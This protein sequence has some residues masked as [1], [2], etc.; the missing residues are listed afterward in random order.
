MQLGGPDYAK[1]APK[2]T[3]SEGNV[4]EAAADGRGAG[5]RYFGAAKALPGVRELFEKGGAAPTVRRTRF[6]MHKA[7]TPDYYGFRD[8]ED[9]V[10]LR[11]EAAADKEIAA[12][13]RAAHLLAVRCCVCV[14]AGRGGARW[15]VACCA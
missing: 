9:G 8:E 3:D 4:L 12:R 5:Y 10:L 1:T 11:V 6:Q 13:V 7:I 14:V 2:V 15:G